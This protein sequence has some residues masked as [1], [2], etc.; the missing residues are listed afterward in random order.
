MKTGT[1]IKR[2][3]PEWSRQELHLPKKVLTNRVLKIYL[4]V[5]LLRRY[6]FIILF[7][8][9]DPHRNCVQTDLTF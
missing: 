2:S 8:G 4:G 7:Y 9:M 1:Y 6:F 3:H 5:C